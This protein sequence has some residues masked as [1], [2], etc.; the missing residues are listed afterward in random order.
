MDSPEERP[1]TEARLPSV[2]EVPALGDVAADGTHAHLT[3][4]A[5]VVAVDTVGGVV[6]VVVVASLGGAYGGLWSG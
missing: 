2:I 6:V 4:L 3:A 1:A 5:A